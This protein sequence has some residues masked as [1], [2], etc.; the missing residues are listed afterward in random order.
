MEVLSFEDSEQ[1]REFNRGAKAA[2]TARNIC[3][4]YGDNSI[5]D[6]TA[7]KCFSLF[8]KDHFNISDIPR[9]CTCELA[10]V[11]NCAHSFIMQH[12]HCKVKKSGVWVPHAV[13]R[14]VHGD[15][16]TKFF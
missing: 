8:K 3:A 15:R 12:L 7:R 16:V 4:V 14:R 6:S 9:L 11:M 5:G 10:N 13:T 2:E 1:S